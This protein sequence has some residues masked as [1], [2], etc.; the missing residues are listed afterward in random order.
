VGDYLTF[1]QT[2]GIKLRGSVRITKIRI[3]DTDTVL[4]SGAQW[5]T[6]QSA[7]F[8]EADALSDLDSSSVL[9]FEG[10]G[11]EGEIIITDDVSADYYLCGDS[12]DNPI[13]TTSVNMARSI[14]DDETAPNGSGKVLNLNVY[15]WRNAS[16]LRLGGFA[17][18]NDSKA[19]GQFLVRIV[20]NIPIGWKIKN[21]HNA[22]GDNAT[23]KWLTSQSGTGE[24]T[25]YMCMVN[26]GSSGSFS[27]INHFALAVDDNYRAVGTI[28]DDTLS[29]RIQQDGSPAGLYLNVVTWKVAFATVYDGTSSD[30]V[31]TTIDKNGIYTGTLRADQIVAGTIQSELIDTDNLIV[32]HIIAGDS[33][34]EHVEIDPKVQ[35]VAIYD[36]DGVLGTALSGKTYSDG[37]DGI[38][39]DVDKGT[40]DLTPTTGSN[41]IQKGTF[42]SSNTTGTKTYMPTLYSTVWYSEDPVCITFNAGKIVVSATSIGYPET[43][44]NNSSSNQ[45]SLLPPTLESSQK[46]MASAYVCIKLQ[47]ADDINFTQN[48]K[49]YNIWQRTAS[50]C[51]SDTVTDSSN[52]HPTVT[53][54]NVSSSSSA[55]DSL[56]TSCMVKSQT[57]GYHRIVMTGYVQAKMSGSKASITWGSSYS[58]G[59]NLAATYINEFYVS[60][61]FAN[62]F[63]LGIS[64][65]QYV[66]VWKDASDKMHFKAEE[67][68]YGLMLSDQGLQY[69]H[70]SGNWIKM[71]L[72]VWKG[73]ITCSSSSSSTSYYTNKH[74]SFNG[75]TITS[76]TRKT[77]SDDSNI[78][79]N[80]I[81]L[82]CAFPDSWNTLDLSVSNA[83]VNLTG[84]G[85]TMMKGT[86]VSISNTSMTIEISDDS[87]AN[88]GDLMIEIY[89]IA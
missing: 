56:I 54:S 49:S 8:V 36:A 63:C 44:S 66:S 24:Y 84:Y 18:A 53:Y 79:K 59:A 35:Q 40:V 48:V 87:S 80:H 69:K 31:T 29:I 2:N 70:H 16:D 85:D 38:Y 47:V 78:S 45:T 28:D 13:G 72:L 68:G 9:V 20:A 81:H 83:I 42:E 46:S 6:S 62:G 7:Q 76:V 88:D 27:T 74:L 22:Y 19:N 50:A 30:K 17:F 71:P 60:R 5:L 57:K 15:R 41:S 73:T 12:D 58:G 26:C 51:S 25:E 39:K 82:V 37:V 52:H 67:S 65:S 1:L 32:Q 64:A 75:A 33:D 86:L 3:K 55:T 4:W 61:Y 77:N 21:Y 23:T 14:I 10:D 34:G 43:S 89:T 11:E